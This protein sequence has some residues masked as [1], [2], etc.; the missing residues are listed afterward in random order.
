MRSFYSECLVGKLLVLLEDRGT[1]PRSRL[2]ED[3]ARSVVSNVQVFESTSKFIVQR[4]LASLDVF[5]LQLRHL[6]IG[7]LT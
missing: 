4:H 5:D 2:Y 6:A 1:L 7:I 3:V